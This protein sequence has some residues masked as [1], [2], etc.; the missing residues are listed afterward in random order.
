VFLG[1]AAANHVQH[2]RL[3]LGEEAGRAGIRFLAAQAGL[4]LLRLRLLRSDA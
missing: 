2:R 4:N 1:L 3:N